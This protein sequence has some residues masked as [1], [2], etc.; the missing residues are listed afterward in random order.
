MKALVVDDS[1]VTCKVLVGALFRAGIKDVDRASDGPEAVEAT[2]SADYDL[3][4]MGWN[5]PNTVGIEVLKAIRANGKTVP[6]IMVTA[7][8]QKGHV[9]DALKAG[10]DNYIVRPFKADTI[11]SKIKKIK[12]ENGRILMI[13]VLGDVH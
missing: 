7:E 12:E 5:M 11:V 9:I 3:V 1:A 2:N 6:V 13:P 8:A 4:L 10:A